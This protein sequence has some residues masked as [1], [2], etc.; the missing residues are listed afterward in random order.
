MEIRWS[1]AAHIGETIHIVGWI[2]EV[3]GRLVRCAAEA[4]NDAGQLVARS[5]A[6]FMRTVQR[7]VSAEPGEDQ[8]GAGTLTNGASNGE[9]PATP[10]CRCARSTV[11]GKENIG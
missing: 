10:L 7:A 6:K 2:E 3:R 9:G 8:E 4:R 11:S 1:R 5:T